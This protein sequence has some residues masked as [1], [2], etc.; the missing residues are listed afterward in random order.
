M[1]FIAPRATRQSR[2]L[3]GTRRN[4]VVHWRLH[5]AACSWSAGRSITGTFSK[6]L[7]GFENPR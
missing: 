5:L 2:R 7:A 1:H 4:D 6:A 3:G